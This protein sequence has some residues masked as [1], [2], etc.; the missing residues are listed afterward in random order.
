[1]EKV[2]L[3]DLLFNRTKV[4]K[5]AKELQHQYPAFKHDEFVREVL[6][7]FPSLELKARIA[8]IAECLKQHLPKDYRLA[9][10]ILLAALP[11]PNDPSLSDNDFGDFIYAPYAEFVAKNGC[12]KEELELSLEALKEI[13]QRF[14]AEDAVRYF[15]NAFPKETLTELLSWTKDPHYHVRRLCSEGTRSKL[16]WAQKIKISIEAPLEILDHLFFDKTRFV[17]RSVANHMNDISKID[18]QLALTRLVQWQKSGKQN[19]SEMNYILRHA[20]RNLVKQ[21]NPEALRLLGFSQETEVQLSN[22]QAPEMVQ[23]N[24][25]LEFS[26][27]LQSKEDANVV[28]DYILYFQNKMGELK[29][30]KVFKLNKLSL[31]KN[32][33]VPV[34]KKHLLRERMTTR[35]LYPGKHELE[36]QIN[37]KRLAK[38]SFLLVKA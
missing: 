37:G 11:T 5:I 16:P 20:L 17:T 34:S 2:L 6:A 15:I 7:Q 21:G 19:S 14:S 29:S 18:P 33:A 10:E 1:M 28:V 3:K 36:I 13:T 4:E 27:V 23:M 38:T 35:T 25:S 9:L 26:F 30:K 31:A 24:S 32:N 22:F 12:S 8:W